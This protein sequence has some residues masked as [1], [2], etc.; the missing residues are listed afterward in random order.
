MVTENRVNESSAT[1]QLTDLVGSDTSTICV[2]MLCEE[3]GDDVDRWILARRQ[4]DLYIAAGLVND[5]EVRRVPIVGE[6]HAVRLL[7][8]FPKI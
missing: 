3:G 5:E 1:R 4:K 2:A 7:A 6:D 8:A